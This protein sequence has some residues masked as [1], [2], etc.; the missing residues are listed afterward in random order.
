M[1]TTADAPVT[2]GDDEAA[3]IAAMFA[4]TT[5]QWEETQEQMAQF[6]NYFFTVIQLLM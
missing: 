5:E 6:V 3:S 4:A 2:L 1:A